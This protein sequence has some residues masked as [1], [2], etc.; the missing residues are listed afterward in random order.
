MNPCGYFRS[1][2]TCCTYTRPT[3]K[4]TALS[5]SGSHSQKRRATKRYQNVTQGLNFQENVASDLQKMVNTKGPSFRSINVEILQKKTDPIKSLKANLKKNRFRGLKK[6]K[7]IHQNLDPKNCVSG[8][9][10]YIFCG[11]IRIRIQ[12]LK[13]I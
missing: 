2:Q 3:S 4:T 7:T 12:S 5:S 10:A 11:R 8:T 1:R 13:P 6:N 9:S